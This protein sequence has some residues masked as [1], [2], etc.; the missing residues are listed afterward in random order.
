MQGKEDLSG[1]F[2]HSR[3]WCRRNTFMPVVFDPPRDGSDSKCML[4]T[5]G[6]HQPKEPAPRNPWKLLDG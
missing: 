1:N 6:V 4:M 5:I 3:F 2:T